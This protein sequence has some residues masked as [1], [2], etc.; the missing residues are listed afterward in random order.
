MLPPKRARSRRQS[1]LHKFISTP[2]PY[3]GD[4]MSKMLPRHGK[5]NSTDMKF[6]TRDHIVP[7]SKGKTLSGNKIIVC[8]ECNELKGPR[9]L[10]EFFI[11]LASHPPSP[12]KL[13]RIHHVKRLLFEMA[14]S[15]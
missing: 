9:D 8:R 7:K 4:E 11:Y 2:C 10:K 3:C 15:D 14:P 6:P 12:R 5:Q 13:K 1:E